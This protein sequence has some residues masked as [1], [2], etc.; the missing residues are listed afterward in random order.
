MMRVNACWLELSDK[1][2]DKDVVAIEGGYR[3]SCQSW[4][5]ILLDLKRR[6]LQHPPELAIG[7]GALGFWNALAEI[8]PLTKRQRCWVHKTVN[9]LNKLPKSVQTKAKE[10]L[11]E[12]WMSPD[13]DAAEKA[14]DH[15]IACYEE[16]YPKATECLEKDKQELLAFYDFPAKH[17]QHIRTTNVIESIFATVRLRTAKTRGCLSRKTAMTMVFKLM[18]SASSKRWI[19]LAGSQHCAEIINGINFKDGVAINK[20]DD[21]NQKRTAA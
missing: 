19:K 2:G 16:K 11:H 3:E 5:E 1:Q 18:Q 13:K 15:F 4:K 12:I 14:F 6:G 8:Y 9:V 10:L 20:I 7:D 21:M 17:W